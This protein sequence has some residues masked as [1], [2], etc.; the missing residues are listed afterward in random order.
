[1]EKISN[2]GL[3][4]LVQIKEDEMIVAGR[5]YKEVKKMVDAKPT[6]WET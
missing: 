6:Y 5:N 4:N 1:M 3:Y 2:K